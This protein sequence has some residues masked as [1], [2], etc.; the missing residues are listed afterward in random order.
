MRQ[1][2]MRVILVAGLVIWGNA[3]YAALAPTTASAG[4]IA[5]NAPQGCNG[6]SDCVSG[7]YCDPLNPMC[8]GGWG[9]CETPS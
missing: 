7:C 3:A 2:L 6:N 8:K 4:T 5:C 9:C 1:K